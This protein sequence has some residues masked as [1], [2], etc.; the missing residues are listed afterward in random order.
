M[1]QPTTPLRRLR[2]LQ[3]VP[4]YF[5]A[6]R[7]GGP[8]RSVHALAKSLVDRGHEVHVFTTSVDGPND[9][10]F[11]PSVPVD[12]DGVKIRYFPVH[13]LRRLYWSPSMATALSREVR[14]FDVVH[15][16]SV[17]LWPTWAAARAA[18]AEGIPYVLSPRGSLGR[19][20]IR[21]KSALIKSAWIHLIERRNLHES[22][23]VHVTSDVEA[24]EIHQLGMRLPPIAHIPNGVGAP[25]K[26][27]TLKEGPF[28]EVTRPYALFLSRINWK[29]GLDR[30][31]E[32]WQWLP[33]LKLMIAGNDEEAYQEKLEA[34]ARRHGVQHRICFLG[35]VAE[36]HKWA[37]YENAE[38]FVLPSYSENFGNVVAEAMMM[39][40]PVVITPQVGLASLVRESGA[41]IVV[42]GEP[43]TLGAAMHS[44]SQDAFRLRSMGQ[45]G[46]LTAREH[47]S[48]ESV[49]RRM[50][51]MYADIANQ[52]PA[53]Q[54]AR[55]R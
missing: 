17:F 51:E 21:R 54:A 1:L 11:S 53:A 29:K 24:N 5:P 47:L 35:P 46:R 40:C 45:R 8:I 3:V 31:L 38:F 48:W 10:D 33:D 28:S 20:V 14:G 39:G 43:A 32:A 30:L 41:G 22:S 7:Y 18:H 16:H 2:I 36:E 55:R 34:L 13:R 19:E 27:L 26:H 44:L 49:G 52:A 12:L 25:S 37:L 50:E 4:T 42:D 23:R 9:L 15:L 6:V